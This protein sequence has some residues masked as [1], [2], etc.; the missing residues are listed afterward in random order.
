MFRRWQ[1]NRPS[2]KALLRI[3]LPVDEGELFHIIYRL[4]GEGINNLLQEACLISKSLWAHYRQNTGEN[5]II[6][7]QNPN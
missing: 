6:K 4:P 5:S 2:G 3:L 7:D 1:E